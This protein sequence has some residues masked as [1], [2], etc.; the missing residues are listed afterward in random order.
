MTAQEQ[1]G[2]DSAVLVQAGRD[3]QVGITYDQARQIALDVFR[4]NFLELSASAAEIA[5]ARARA[6][7]EDYLETQRSRNPGGIGAANDPGFQHALYEAEKAYASTGDSD[8]KDVLIDVLV[9]RAAESKRGL[10]QI[11]LE[12][13][14]ATAPKL[15]NDQFDVLSLV[16]LIRYTVQRGLRKPGDFLEYLDAFLKP[17][18]AELSKEDARYQHLEYANCA[19][20]SL[21]EVG[22]GGAFRA[23]YPG[24]FST[25]FTKAEI[26]EQKIDE[27]AG[28]AELIIACMREPEKFQFDWIDRNSFNAVCARRQYTKVEK[29]KL[30]VFEDGHLLDVAGVEGDLVQ[31]RS[32]LREL[33]DVWQHAA[34]K[35]LTL[36]SVGIAL[37]HANVRR[38][39][40][41][42]FDLGIWIK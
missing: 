22:L 37:A 31:A 6:F 40:G 41:A 38:K 1:Q 33:F 28:I 21:G 17:F 18:T 16:F 27:I 13:A 2:G 30:K 14:I 23:E 29:S 8:L 9:D 5:I 36:T 42:N 7:I 24:I 26:S 20:I 15:T 34:I 32:W 39:T 25:G 4:A 10:M 35:N 19:A 11:V 3:V 12:E